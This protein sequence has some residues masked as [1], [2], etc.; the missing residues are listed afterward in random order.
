[1]RVLF[2]ITAL[3][4]LVLLWA[5]LAIRRHVRAAAR[6][7]A[8]RNQP[9]A[10]Q[11]FEAELR[12]ELRSSRADAGFFRGQP[13]NLSD[14]KPGRHTSGLRPAIRDS[15]VRA[16]IASAWAEACGKPACLLRRD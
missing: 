8:E 10:R 16:A 14:P 11:V 7:R 6:E 12:S 3:C 15:V 2:A 9:P 13:D 5:G 1:M 4:L